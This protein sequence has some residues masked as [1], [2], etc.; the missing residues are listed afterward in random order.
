[1]EPRLFNILKTTYVTMLT[2]AIQERSY[3]VLQVTPKWKAL[4]QYVYFLRD[5]DFRPTFAGH[6]F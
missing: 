6:L 2:K 5:V 1:M 3:R 4:K